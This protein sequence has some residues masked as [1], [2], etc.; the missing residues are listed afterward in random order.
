MKGKAALVAGLAAGYVLGTRD[1][2]GRYQEIKA[3]A[4][5]LR[6]DPRVRDRA[7][8]AEDLVRRKAPGVADRLAGATSGRTGGGVGD[9]PTQADLEGGSQGPDRPTP[10]GVAA[11]ESATPLTPTS[12]G[13]TDG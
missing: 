11:T 3:R 12:G 7:A 8:K 13:D 9:T 1:G 5:R 6:S 10:S 2:R 4:D